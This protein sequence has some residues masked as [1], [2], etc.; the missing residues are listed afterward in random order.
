MDLDSIRNFCLSLAHATEDF[1]FGET[2]LVFRIGGKIFALTDI[3]ALPLSIS[4]KCDPQRAIELRE[5]Y[6]EIRPGWHL[7][8]KH[9]NTMDLSGALPESLIHELIKHSY[10]LVFDSLRKSDREKLV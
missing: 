5:R 3:E 7:N 1:P 4:L 10:N 6:D 9:W 2:T 8:K